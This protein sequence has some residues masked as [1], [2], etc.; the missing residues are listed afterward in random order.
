MARNDIRQNAEIQGSDL[1]SIL[2]SKLD[3]VKGVLQTLATAPAIHN[4]ELQRSIDIINLRQESTSDITDFYFWL[5]EDGKV[6][7]S[8]AFQNNEAVQQQFQDADLSSREYFTE[9]KETLRSYYI[10]D[11]A[12]FDGVPRVFL[13]MPIVTSAGEGQG[14]FKGVIVAAIQSSTIGDHLKQELFPGFES[15]VS[16]MDKDGIV[17]YTRSEEL[18]GK[19]IFSEEIQSRL[20]QVVPAEKIDEVNGI[21]RD[22]LEGDTGSEDVI[23]RGQTLTIAYYPVAIEG[24]HLLT[25]F[26]IAPHTLGSDVAFLIDQQRTFSTMLVAI[27][28]A[29]AFGIAFLVLTWNRR[30]EGIV[31]ARTTQLEES[32]RQLA[33]ANEQL[34]LH[35]RMQR[36]FINVA[37]HELRTPT[38]A[39]LGY[40]DLFYMKPDSRDEAMGAIARNAQRLERLANNILDVTKIEGH[41]LELNKEEF[42]LNEVVQGTLEDARRQMPNGDI[43]FASGFKQDVF[44]RADKARITQVISNL[45]GNAIKFTKRGKISITTDL[46]DNEDIVSVQD[47]GTG[48]HQDIIPRL[49]TKFTSKSQTGTG[50]GLFISKSIIEAHGGRIQAENNPDGK[51]ATFSFSLPITPP[52]I[53]DAHKNQQQTA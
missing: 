50:L 13:S 44:I 53:Y 5:D 4:L 46:K 24:Q 29:V 38:Q 52:T 31:K 9:P 16:L 17:L 34:Q 39:I 2:E 51:G 37:A 12:S 48:I 3:K 6:V 40:S 28:G 14:V 21:L 32:N 23:S 15:R 7:W 20:T 36:E 25:L 19:S 18:R 10:S 11:L 45:L 22:S 27:I 8:S 42:N 41:K 35:D 33:Q 47:T 30:L 1:S 43:E 49:F 26:I